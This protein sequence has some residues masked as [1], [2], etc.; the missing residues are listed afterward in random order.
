M[1]FLSV[2]R[3]AVLLVSLGLAAL[4][5]TYFAW[6]WTAARSEARIE[7]EFTRTAEETLE[8]LENQLSRYEDALLAGVA[9]VSALDRPPT[10][11]EW[12]AFA[13]DLDLTDRYPGVNG[14][15]VIQGVARED[16]PALIE[17]QRR[18]RPEFKVH[19]E[20]DADVHYPIVYIEP[21]APNQAAVGLDMAFET[22]RLTALMAARDE[23]RP[24]ITGPI[25]L[26]QDSTASAGFLMF[27]PVFGGGSDG[28]GAQAP[29]DFQGAVYA[30]FVV[31]TLLDGLLHPDAPDITWRI[32][33]G[34]T[35]LYD[36]FGPD[37]AS[38]DSDPLV[39]QQITRS[40]YGRTWLFELRT[41]TSFRERYR[42]DE[43]AIVL[44]SGLCMT[45]L[46]LALFGALA[47]SNRRA[48]RLAERATRDLSTERDDLA[49]INQS[50][51][52]VSYAAA[53]HL[54]TPL[55]SIQDTADYLVEDFEALGPAA[56]ASGGI[57]EH[58]ATL[59]RMVG[60]MDKLVSTILVCTEAPAQIRR[61]RWIDV[62]AELRNLAD[63][64]G[65]SHD[66]VFCEGEFF[67]IHFPPVL[68]DQIF[69]NL[70]ENAIK[71]GGSH[72]TAQVSCR[73]R[74]DGDGAVIEIA[75][76]GP[77]LDPDIADQIR[78]Y[79]TSDLFTVEAIGVGL[80]V[81]KRTLDLVRGRIV[82]D[83][84]PGRGTRFEV[85]LPNVLTPR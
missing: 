7:A 18:E 24:R 12:R 23:G 77:G 81:V 73:M 33:D 34:E 62:H 27:A 55:R 20:T 53:H 30:P 66:R 26:V 1:A 8:R 57:A 70:L 4:A 17:A 40:L 14:I 46:L 64:W 83:S 69:G 78:H 58:V 63:R 74:S 48:A 54:R 47:R 28:G 22:S 68:F 16:L 79:F 82:V 29:G 67:P 9:L 2:G 25:V 42:N 11:A 72:G 80:T 75:D 65:T 60:R 71:H 19:P 10:Y 31:R 39:A 5:V 52:Q 37:Q 49:A 6:S 36:E 21:E 45:A 56:A 15:G 44:W 41:T 84:A 85:H 32:R 50:L 35:I 51:E 13:D 43:A 3:I 76:D 59:R 38:Y 61:K